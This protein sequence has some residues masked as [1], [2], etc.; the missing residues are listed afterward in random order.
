MHAA[1]TAA[2]HADIQQE[3]QDNR[4]SDGSS[5]NAH[6]H[7][8]SCLAPCKK[9]SGAYIPCHSICTS[10]TST[11]C[12][13]NKEGTRN[14]PAS[15]EEEGPGNLA[16]SVQQQQVVEKLTGSVHESQ[17]RSAAVPGEVTASTARV[18]GTALMGEALH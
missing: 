11:T 17:T 13:R 6:A 3:P 5:C 8:C 9:D 4:H 12:W 1:G 16:Q 10:T 18:A 14:I 15:I 7:V 2:Q